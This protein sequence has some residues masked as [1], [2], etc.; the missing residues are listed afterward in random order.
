MLLS[1][2]AKLPTPEVQRDAWLCFWTGQAL[3][4]IDEEQAR[5][6]FGH[7]YS[8]FATDGNTSGLRLAAASSVV[9]LTLEWADLQQLDVWIGRHSDAGGDTIVVDADRFEPYLLMGIV[10]VALV[11][12]F[13]PPQIDRQALIARLRILLESPDA[14][15]SDDQRLQAAT[16]L[17]KHGEAFNEY[18]LAQNVIIA[19]RSL[20]KS[21][22]GGALHRGRWFI[23]AADTQLV[24]GDAKLARVDLSEARLL[25]EQSQSLRLSFEF[26]FA[27][28]DHYMKAHDLQLAADELKQLEDI[29]IQTPP[30]QRAEYSRMRA[31]LLLL[32]GY[33][34]EGLHWAEE[35]MRLAVPAGLTG[36]SLRMFETELIYALTANDR[37]SEALELLSQQEYEPREVRLALENCLDFLA[38]GK[39]HLQALRV[40]LQ[41]ARQINFLNLLDRARTPLA[42]ICEAALANQIE[43]DFVSRLIE[44]KRLSPPPLAGPHWPWPVHVRTLGGFRLDVHGKR[45]RPSHKAQD[46]PLELLKLLVTC[47]ALG[48]DSAE[49][50]WISERLW[51]DADADNARKSLDMTVG[52]LRRLLDN[53]DSVV[54]HEGRLQLSPSVVWTDI[55]LL[56]HAISHAQFRRD[57]HAMGITGP[58]GET[59]ASIT[60]LLDNY[61]GPFLA[62]EEGPA[63]LL[64]GRE[65]IAARVRQAL[66]AADA[67]LEGAADTL[68]IPAL[69]RAFAADPTSEDLAQALM[70]AHLRLGQNSEA[71]RVYRRLR[72]MLSLLLSI[73]P[74]LNR[75]IF[76]T[77]LMPLNRKRSLT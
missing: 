12:G 44:I 21:C 42:Q 10:C 54:T 52:R 20:P 36:A 5:V 23:A 48:R 61:T 18:E 19:T 3:L 72:E 41:N 62:D 77:R 8:A 46:K 29:A 63:W 25:A 51:P 30:A 39:S 13:Y 58:G 6:W 74:S 26:G 37:V 17:V 56:L 49:K 1:S 67:M 31:R 33:L 66:L 35:A 69:E 14:W 38:H 53:E 47:Q 40:G 16:I 43:T 70:R 28:A 50:A 68:L 22:A 64:A 60:T 7:A 59:A 34:T 2:I 27:S 65:A 45:Y 11:R 15:L 71:I 75:T 76:V 9:T 57:Q 4:R 32:Q 55:R 73:A 24:G